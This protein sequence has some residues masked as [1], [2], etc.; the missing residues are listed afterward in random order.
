MLIPYFN[1]IGS[2]RKI[3]IVPL[4]R[5]G[6]YLQFFFQCRSR[7]VLLDFNLI[8]NVYAKE[9]TKIRTPAARRI[10]WNIHQLELRSHLITPYISR[11][12]LNSPQHRKTSICTLLISMWATSLEYFRVILVNRAK[13][14]KKKTYRV[15]RGEDAAGEVTP[16]YAGQM[17]G[18]RQTKNCDAK[19]G[20]EDWHNADSFRSGGQTPQKQPVEL[21]PQNSAQ[22]AKTCNLWV[23]DHQRTIRHWGEGSI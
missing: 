22:G 10:P 16:P 14:S 9:F 17:G 19:D 7:L 5:R 15:P 11:H 13:E 4:S 18:L 6:A 23:L 21:S 3:P 1:I 2:L 12:S 8:P 20:I